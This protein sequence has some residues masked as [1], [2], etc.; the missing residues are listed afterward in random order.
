MIPLLPITL[1]LSAVSVLLNVVF[2]K[3]ASPSVTKD[4]SKKLNTALELKLKPLHYHLGKA[5]NKVDVEVLGALIS[6]ELAQFVEE[7]PDVYEKS[8]LK[9]N[10][11]YVRHE[12]KTL[13]ELK[14]HKKTLQRQMMTSAYTD[15]IRKQY[16]EACRAISDLKKQEKKKEEL[17]TTLHQEKLFQKNRWE[18]SK[19]VCRGELGKENLAPTFNS[20]T[21]NTHYNSYSTPTVTDFS[22]THW[23]PLIHN[24]PG[25]T[26]FTDFNMSPIRPKDIFGVLKA[27]NH[28]SSPGPDG[29][30][31]GILFNLPSTHHILATLFNKVLATSAVPE[32]WGESILKLIHKKGTTDD[33]GNFRPIALSNSVVKTFHLILAKRF[34]TYLT[35]N[36]FIDPKIQKAFLPGISGCTEHNVVMEEVIKDIKSRRKTVHIAFFDLADAF[37]SVPHDL[38]HHTLQ[39]NFIPQPVQD[40]LKELYNKT[41]SK[42]VTK[43]FQSNPFSFKKGVTQG[44]PLSPI[45]FIL[46]FQPII[47]FLM[48]NEQYGAVINGKRVITLPYADDFC[49]ITRDKRTQQ[50]LISQIHIHIQSMGMALKPSKCR[51]FSIISGTPKQTF[52][53]IDHTEISSIAV[54]EQT[55]LGKMIFYSGKS[56]ETLSYFKE[57]FTGKLNHIENTMIRS[58]YKMWIYINYFLPS[59]RFL[60]TVHDITAT[61]LNKL[62]AICHRYIK[63]WSG[64]ARSGT[65]LV[66]H[67]SQGLGIHTI[68]SLYE[69]THALNHNAMRL[70]GDET[71]NAALDNAISREAQFVKKGSSVVRAEETH[72]K[73]MATEKSTN[74][75]IKNSVKKIVHTNTLEQST[76]HLNTLC[77]QGEFLKLSI[78][79]QQDP[80]W[81]A[82]IWNLKK[83]TAK[84]LLNSTIHTLPTQNNLKLWNKSMSDRCHLCKNRDSTLHTLSGCKV[85]LDQKRYTYRHDNIIKYI[86]DCIDKN[87]FK[88]HS[89]ID[90]HTTQNGGT[91][92]AHMTVT[93]LKPDI[94]ITDEAKKTVHI[95]E[96]T[97]PF[98]SNI[99][100]RNT[101]KTNKYSHFITDITSHN[102]FL[103][104]FEV[105]ARGFLSTE[106]TNRLKEI[107]KHYCLKTV[108]QSKFLHNISALAITGSYYIYTA[109]K[110]PTWSTP[111]FLS[112]LF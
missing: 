41:R 85:A 97:V 20:N 95:V 32:T 33:P 6:Q 78:Q 99:K 86:V 37:G 93:D 8:E 88:V 28:K 64:V 26:N 35:S 66:F 103:T 80:T 34:T 70:K 29:I 72:L 96:L 43:T 19:S 84:F 7:H 87:K 9:S 60:L 50:R 104:A 44:D 55:F 40:Y 17:K 98:E 11:T 71:V 42:V 4:E 107:H 30:T 3:F 49:L 14:K 79:E 90:G 82:F 18:F 91:I 16:W 39:R 10:A 63:K 112:P 57:V 102:V 68:K 31:Y 89:D 76:K 77:K 92:P 69:E 62:D 73:A 46:T 101:E 1:A 23:F 67:M 51:T 75:A 2:P 59:I 52:F 61:D 111:G 81:K 21:A 54:E 22:K 100:V 74:V 65:N 56:K 48:Q 38:I 13:Q 94:T 15:T 109:R 83:G 110:Q 12:S 36:K 106:N 45:I 53:H 58:E 105:G 25:D 47:D 27:A 108:N 5:T 24:S